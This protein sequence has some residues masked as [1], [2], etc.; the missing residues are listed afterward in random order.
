MPIDHWIFA[1]LIQCAI[2]SY[3]IL[4]CSGK[5]ATDKDKPEEK[6]KDA[7]SKSTMK[8]VDGDKKKEDAKKEVKKEPPAKAAPQKAT[9]PTA[10]AAAP[11]P[12]E[13]KSVNKQP[14]PTQRTDAPKELDGEKGAANKSQQKSIQKTQPLSIKD[15]PKS[16]SSEKP[17]IINSK[18]A[19]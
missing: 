11:K 1:A 13:A 14:E 15:D 9:A 6:K 2:A 4:K 7:A 10:P 5:K 3:I 8:K 16:A 17:S 18:A 12:E 19:K